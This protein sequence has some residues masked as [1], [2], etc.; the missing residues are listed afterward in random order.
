MKQPITTKDLTA[1][2][3]LSLFEQWASTKYNHFYNALE[4]KE[5]RKFMKEAC[6]LHQK[7]RDLLVNYLEDNKTGE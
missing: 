6:L 2:T 3:D 1:L 5:I 7:Q 4:D